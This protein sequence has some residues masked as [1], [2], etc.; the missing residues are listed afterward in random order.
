YL[1]PNCDARDTNHR[2]ATQLFL[3]KCLVHSLRSGNV[4]RRRRWTHMWTGSAPT[5]EVVSARCALPSCD[6]LACTAAVR[7]PGV[8]PC[9][10]GRRK[11][12]IVTA[13]ETVGRQASPAQACTGLSYYHRRRGY[14]HRHGRCLCA[15]RPQSRDL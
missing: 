13:P 8:P 2:F 15:H 14:C 9:A 1:L 11:D 12:R 7:A 3:R 5:L 4:V 6:S 10:H